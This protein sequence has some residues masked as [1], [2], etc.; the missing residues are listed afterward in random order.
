MSFLHT[1]VSG[2]LPFHGVHSN[3]SRFFSTAYFK[4]EK[5]KEAEFQLAGKQ[6]IKIEKEAREKEERWGQAGQAQ[7]SLGREGSS[8][9]EAAD[10][11]RAGWGIQ[12]TQGE[13]ENGDEPIEKGPV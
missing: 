2:S 10:G 4:I 13:E 8:I 1:T 11:G 5:K 6:R 12:E 9:E 3:V 7:P